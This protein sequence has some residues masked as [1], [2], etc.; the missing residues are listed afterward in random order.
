MISNGAPQ[1]EAYTKKQL[2]FEDVIRY[3]III[4][5]AHHII[6]RP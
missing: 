2:A 3:F 6:V 4:D 1:L 5:E